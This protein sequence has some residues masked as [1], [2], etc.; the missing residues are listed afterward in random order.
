MIFVNF[1]RSSG[2]SC[3]ILIHLTPFDFV[4]I[5]FISFPEEMETD[6]RAAALWP[7]FQFINCPFPRSFGPALLQYSLMAAL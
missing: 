3:L 6:F 7:A 2:Y 1:V 5:R 4:S